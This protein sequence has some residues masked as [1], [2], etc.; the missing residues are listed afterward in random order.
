MSL[1]AQKIIDQCVLMF[2]SPK[3]IIDTLQSK[4]KIEPC[5]AEERNEFIFLIFCHFYFVPS[6]QH[7]LT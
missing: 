6:I 5:V 4:A 3:E 2:M 1:Q 7:Y